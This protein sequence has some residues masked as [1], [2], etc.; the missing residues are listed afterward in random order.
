MLPW[1]CPLLHCPRLHSDSCLPEA[2]GPGDPE[3]VPSGFLAVEPSKAVAPP[4]CENVLKI[5][6]LGLRGSLVHRPAVK[7]DER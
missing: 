3:G 1:L 7:R 5:S 2:A 6:Y 4:T